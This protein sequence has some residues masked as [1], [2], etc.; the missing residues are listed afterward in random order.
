MNNHPIVVGIDG[1]P[2]AR[3]AVWWAAKEAAR[4]HSPLLLV[5]GYGIPAAFY[6]ETAPPQDW[7]ADKEKQSRDWLAE[8]AEIAERADP[9]AELYTESFLDSAVPLLISESG[10]ATMVVVGF[11]AR[12]VLGELVMGSTGASLAAHGHCPIVV[13]RGRDGR[14][15][16]ADDP[17]VVGVDG[18][19]GSV[20]ATGLAFEEA[21]LRGVSL[22]ALHA[23][24]GRERV[25][26]DAVLAPW[27]EKYPEVT[28]Q[29]VTTREDPRKGLLDWSGRAQLV[30]VGSRGRGGF[31]GLL[32]G[33]TSHA[34][35]HHADCPVLIARSSA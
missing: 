10:S 9:D 31:T 14:L 18:G 12:S 7:L 20:A 2:G 21:A 1:S 17:V 15:I 13:V 23:D 26:L 35:I 22:V 8:A 24:E 28:V 4:R 25:S 27:R 30:V 3:R 29:E 33:S 34:V 32:L 6:N 16:S 11:T 19:Q 5:H